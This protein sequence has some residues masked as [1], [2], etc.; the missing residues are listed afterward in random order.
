MPTATSNAKAASAKKAPPPAGRP[1]PPKL[2][3]G[4]SQ[5]QQLVEKESSVCTPGQEPFISEAEGIE[6]NA[7]EKE[8]HDVNVADGSSGSAAPPKKVPGRRPPLPR[9]SSTQLGGKSSVVE[10]NESSVPAESEGEHKEQVISVGNVEKPPS[11]NIKA[12]VVKRPPAP[13][14]AS[15]PRS[16]IVK[17]T[18]VGTGGLGELA[19]QSEDLAPPSSKLATMPATSEVEETKSSATVDA[20]DNE[21]TAPPPPPP[22]A[23]AT[24]NKSPVVKRP[25]A[26]RPTSRPHSMFV[27]SASVSG[28]PVSHAATTK[29]KHPESEADLKKA[30]PAVK[31]PAVMRP[32]APKRTP[33][34]K[35]GPSL[36]ETSVASKKDLQ[37]DSSDGGTVESAGD[38]STPDTGEMASKKED[39]EMIVES[40][41]PKPEQVKKPAAPSARRPPPPSIHK[42]KETKPELA[43]AADSTDTPVSP[44]SIEEKEE[45][46]QAGQD[47]ED[48]S[49]EVQQSMPMPSS[50][51]KAPSIPEVQGD[52]S[53]PQEVV[54]GSDDSSV[55]TQYLQNDEKVLSTV[56][57]SRAKKFSIK[58]PSPPATA[59]PKSRSPTPSAAG[60]GTPSPPP[61]SPTENSEVT[62]NIEPVLKAPQ[63]SQTENPS[64]VLLLPAPLSKKPSIKR[65]PPPATT[66]PKSRSPTPVPVTSPPSPPVEVSP[67]KSQEPVSSSAPQL[68]STIQAPSPSPSSSNP[69]L[70]DDISNHDQKETLGM[71]AIDSTTLS[72]GS[73]EEKEE[74][75]HDEDKTVPVKDE[76][77]VGSDQAAASEAMG[78]VRSRPVRLPPTAKT[79]P[80][81]PRAPQR[82]NL[83]KT[84]SSDGTDKRGKP[85]GSPSQARG[86][87]STNDRS[88]TTRRAPSPTTRRAPSPTTRRAPSPT[89]RRAPSPTTRR[90]PSPATR[91]APSPATRRAPSPATRRAPSPTT[92]RA[93]SLRQSRTNSKGRSTGKRWN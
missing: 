52:Q 84:P 87:S 19:A 25:P 68:S 70:S 13:R 63:D 91:R 78:S 36:L 39:A 74:R 88:P 51:S 31:R 41:P 4:Q 24:A 10:K 27:K 85:P 56:A 6:G 75:E 11:I 38:V 5:Q 65:P 8:P 21:R 23:T 93:P 92:R 42:R 40:E 12:P 28:Q 46:A 89:T 76:Q 7:D 79:R 48:T 43:S 67:S 86:A 69:T 73:G 1:P 29:P 32:P 64:T 77:A 34:K 53:L 33:G 16:M 49:A 47:S 20:R 60:T 35:G 83:N 44:P 58:K 45:H 54:G 30:A 55:A 14:P 80:P 62:V 59:K 82:A 57:A 50:E 72:Q 15:R 61:V 37:A 9:Q 22:P 26:P 3:K 81:P 2:T 66:R 71:S 17:T 18:P 90:A